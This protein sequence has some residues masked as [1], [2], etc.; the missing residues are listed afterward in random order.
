M[1]MFRNLYRWPCATLSLVRADL[2][3]TK[4]VTTVVCDLLTSRLQH[5][6]CRLN[7][8]YNIFTIVAHNMKTVLDFETC[9]KTLRQS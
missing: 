3:G 2:D 5:E 7:Q 9:F 6:P 8:T 4:F 1:Q